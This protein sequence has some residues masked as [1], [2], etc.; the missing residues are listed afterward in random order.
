MTSSVTRSEK[1]VHETA[2][3]CLV[4]LE[5]WK[6]R[7]EQK[8]LEEARIEMVKARDKAWF[9]FLHPRDISDAGVKAWLRERWED[10]NLW[11][12]GSRARQL[13]EQLEAIVSGTDPYTGLQMQLSI[14]D[15]LL[16]ETYSVRGEEDGS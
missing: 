5:I 6:Q 14:S 2:K 1:W 3:E 16:L 9:K 13:R 4:N 12:I 7:K 15:S 10:H 8:I 11:A